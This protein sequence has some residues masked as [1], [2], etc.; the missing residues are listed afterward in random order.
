M[1]SYKL[2]AGENT[3]AESR[4][5]GS[6]SGFRVSQGLRLFRKSLMPTDLCLERCKR[7]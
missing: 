6:V 5:S 2:E 4:I 7:I 1:R 3:R